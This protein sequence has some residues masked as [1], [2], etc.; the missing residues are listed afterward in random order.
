MIRKECPVCYELID[1]KLVE[2][3]HCGYREDCV[4]CYLH[5]KEDEDV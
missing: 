4:C 5:R 3:P 2:C 1:E